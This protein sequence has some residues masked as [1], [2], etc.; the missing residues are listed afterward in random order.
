MLY[1][2]YEYVLMFKFNFKM[3]F[4]LRSPPFFVFFFFIHCVCF[5]AWWYCLQNTLCCC[6]YL[7]CSM[8]ASCWWLLDANFLCGHWLSFWC[9]WMFNVEVHHGRSAE[10]VMFTFKHLDLTMQTGYTRA[11][12]I[13]SIERKVLM[14]CIVCAVIPLNRKERTRLPVCWWP[15]RPVHAGLS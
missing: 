7:W 15:A 8:L 11:D 13:S 9:C 10:V 2:L 6:I 1:D 3:T 4:F 12:G 5:N 14:L